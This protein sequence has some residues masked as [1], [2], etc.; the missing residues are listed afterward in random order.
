MTVLRVRNVIAAAYQT[1]NVIFINNALQNGLCGNYIFFGR[2]NIFFR[3]I[4][5]Q[6]DLNIERINTIQKLF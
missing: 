1:A 3:L 4:S 5:A 2:R 6:E